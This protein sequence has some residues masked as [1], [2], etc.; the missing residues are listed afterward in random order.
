M[1]TSWN[2]IA[3]FSSGPMQ[4][5]SARLWRI[6]LTS[7]QFMVI[8]CLVFQSLYNLLT[9]RFVRKRHLITGL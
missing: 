3:F 8:K 4:A 1:M 6:T 9:I 2:E 7:G 5:E